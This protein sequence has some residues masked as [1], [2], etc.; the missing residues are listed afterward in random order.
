MF[1]WPFR[2]AETHEVGSSIATGTL[3]RVG[4]R[5]ASR[6]GVSA[7]PIPDPAMVSEAQNSFQEYLSKSYTV[8]AESAWITDFAHSK[9]VAPRFTR[10]SNVG[11]LLHP[12]RQLL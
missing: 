1:V 10:R 5:R 7:A 12:F 11:C 4:G 6:W 9:Q 2:G 8:T 3:P